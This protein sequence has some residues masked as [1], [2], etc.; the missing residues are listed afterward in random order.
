M[1][2]FLIITLILLCTACTTK[3][4]YEGVAFEKNQ[5]EDWENPGVYEINKEAPR[6]HFIPYAS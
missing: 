6:A 5:I 3:N 2:G 4:S 1:R